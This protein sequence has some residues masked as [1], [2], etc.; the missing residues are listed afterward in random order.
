MATAD[1]RRPCE[2]KVFY[3]QPPLRSRDLEI[4]G[5]G[6]REWMTSGIVD[7]P[8]GTDDWLLMFFHQATEIGVDQSR[9]RSEPGSL[10]IWRPRS[11]HLYGR[12]GQG[13]NHSWIHAQGTLLERLVAE[14]ELPVDRPI[15]GIDAAWIERCVHD[16]H[17]EISGH[18]SP[19]ATIV[20]NA[21]H[22]F[23]R[24]V[25]RARRPAEGPA[26][27]ATLLAV[28]RHLESHFAEPTGLEELARR[29]ELSPNHFCGEFRRWFGA[30]PIDF[31]IRLRLER[32]R[33]LL[34]DRSESIAAVA[35]AVGYDDPHYFTKLVRRRFG[36]PPSAL[37]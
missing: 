13:W 3:A 24:Q 28:R 31:L 16:I 8:R 37:R 25:A 29:A 10:V 4:E 26:V 12:I 18:V 36:C 23:L 11:P 33:L 35:K 34:R 17:R 20:A 32:A 9:V 21:L 30:S 1:I 5:V 7:R 2:L 6:A 27:P 15:S 19:D 22:T 14:L